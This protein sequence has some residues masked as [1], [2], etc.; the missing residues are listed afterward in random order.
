MLITVNKTS[1]PKASGVRDCDVD[2]RIRYPSPFS[3]PTNSP[4]TAP[5]TANVIAIFRPTKICGIAV[6][7]RILMKVWG[8]LAD[9]ERIR[10][11]NGAG[12][13]ERPVAV[14]TMMGKKQTEKN[15]DDLGQRTE[16]DP[17]RKKRRDRDLGHGL[18]CQQDGI[19]RDLEK[20][21]IDDRHRERNADGDGEREADQ[22]LVEGDQGMGGE[23]ASPVHHRSPI[24]LG[25]GS[26]QPG[27]CSCA[28]I[29]SHSTIRAMKVSVAPR[30]ALTGDSVGSRTSSSS[31]ATSRSA[32][33]S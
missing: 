12:T 24:A 28:T 27:I 33:S 26:S 15:H 7:K 6:G 13:A 29:S 10:S 11:I 5:I 8:A 25:D 21:R 9:S 14:A 17:E 19:D 20:G 23:L 16:A 30:T 2:T 22:R 31:S 3:E 4:I 1:A 32:R 18:E